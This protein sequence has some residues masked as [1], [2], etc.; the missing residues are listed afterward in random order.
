MQVSYKA[1]TGKEWIPAGAPPKEKK[2]PE[3]KKEEA[4]PKEKVEW[5]EE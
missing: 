1:T 2:K 3:K 5:A 4:K